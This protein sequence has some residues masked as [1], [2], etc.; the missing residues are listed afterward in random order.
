MLKKQKYSL[1]VLQDKL[2]LACKEKSCF[3]VGLVGDLGSGK[4]T[5]VS[6]L[7]A[8]FDS[9]LKDQVSSPT[10]AIQQIYETKKQLFYHFDL[11]RIEEYEEL[12]E[13]GFFES[14]D[15]QT[16]ITFIEWV[17]VFP[18]LEGHCD[19]IIEIIVTATGERSYT[20]R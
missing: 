20:V 13:V 17:N 10:F 19:L 4:T 7:L 16:A 12:E 9:S 18:S 11:Y 2:L 1:Q 15:S 14:I 3:I 6:N 5:F 8:L